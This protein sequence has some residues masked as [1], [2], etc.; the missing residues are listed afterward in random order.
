L[1]GAFGGA[2]GACWAIAT[3][4]ISMSAPAAS[5]PAAMRK[6]ADCF[7]DG[8]KAFLIC[9]GTKSVSAHIRAE[10]AAGAASTPNEAIE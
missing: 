7:K 5:T 1:A 8:M 3:A 9:F 6:G 2:A 10:A 4:G